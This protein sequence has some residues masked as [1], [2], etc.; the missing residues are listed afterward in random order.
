M[1][2]VLEIC[3]SCSFNQSLLCLYYENKCVGA[4]YDETTVFSR[5]FETH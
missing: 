3:L 5:S 1:Q 4:S 2:Q